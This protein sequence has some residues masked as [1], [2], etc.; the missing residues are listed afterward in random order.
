MNQPSISVVIPTCHRND[1]LAKCLDCLAPGVQ[2]LPPDQYEVIVTDDGS[3][4]TAEQMVR[5]NYPW[6]RWVAGP[7]KGPAANRNNGARAARGEWLA[8]TDD[9][10][11][12]SP[13]W[14]SG[15]AQALDGETSVYEGKTTCEVGIH[16][17]LYE[18]PINL[19]GGKL[20]SC[21][22]LIQSNLFQ[23]LSGFEESFTMPAM[24][25][26]EFYER[27]CGKEEPV[28]FVNMAIV[29]HPPRRKPY[30]WRLGKKYQAAVQYWYKAGNSGSYWMPFLRHV[31]HSLYLL[32]R[33][34][35]SQ[36]LVYAYWSLVLETAYIVFHL[37]LWQKQFRNIY[38]SSPHASV[39]APT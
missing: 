29:D 19:T 17:P 7:C 35:L 6:V 37:P 32:A 27:L 12:P 21:N 34:Q 3:R 24:E 39:S 30:G 4:S 38:I 2:T 9:D 28:T 36:D 5:D 25:D 13:G 31:K 20:W 1:L 33:F 26:V 8:F 23:K 16:S 11:L 14:L 22:F 18:A 10:C 15:Y